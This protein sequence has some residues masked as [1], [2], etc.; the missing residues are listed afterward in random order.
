M[1]A[2]LSWETLFWAIGALVAWTAYTAIS[3]VYFSPLAKIPGPKLAALTYWYEIYYDI[4]VGPRFPWKVEELHENYG[5]DC[6]K[7][8]SSSSDFKQKA[9]S[10]V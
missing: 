4:I 10:S 2:I 6:S 3:R 8:R 1:I 9:Q 5:K 7:W